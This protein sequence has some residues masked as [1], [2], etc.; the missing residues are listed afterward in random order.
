MNVGD[1]RDG[2]LDPQL[3]DGPWYGLGQVIRESKEYP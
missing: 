3:P 1:C 2:L